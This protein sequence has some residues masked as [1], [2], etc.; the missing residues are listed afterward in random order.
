MD[1]S[2]AQADLDLIQQLLSCPKGAETLIL[3]G[4]K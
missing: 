1:E 4:G 3:Y 2:R